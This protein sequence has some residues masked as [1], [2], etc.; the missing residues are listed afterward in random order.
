M[1]AKRLV[2]AANAASRNCT[3]NVVMTQIANEATNK[4]AR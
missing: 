1:K 3:V 2:Q 4:I